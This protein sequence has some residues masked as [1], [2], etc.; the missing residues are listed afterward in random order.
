[1]YL[2]KIK[3]LIIIIMHLVLI[4]CLRK[5]IAIYLPELCK[6]KYRIYSLQLL[7]KRYL[8]INYSSICCVCALYSGLSSSKQDD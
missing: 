2:L 4:E 1:M 6:L 7:M 3:K 5:G 8:I